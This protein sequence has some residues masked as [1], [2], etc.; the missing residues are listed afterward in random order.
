MYNE[1]KSLWLDKA[2]VRLIVHREDALH[3]IVGGN[4][5]RKLYYN[6]IHFKQN[7]YQ[8]I[9]TFGGAFSNHIAAVAYT[10]FL[11]GIKTIGIIRGNELSNNQSKNIT[12]Q[13][14]SQHGMQLVYVD[15]KTYTNRYS[16]QYHNTLLKTYGN[17]FVIPEGGCNELGMQGCAQIINDIEL[18]FDYVV[19]P[20]GTGTTLA[21]IASVVNKKQAIGIQVTQFSIDLP[22]QTILKADLENQCHLFNNA[23]PGYGKSNET[24]NAFCANFTNSFNIPIEPIYTGKMFQKL[25]Q[26]IEQGWFKRGDTIVA[27]H[28]GGLQYLQL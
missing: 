25:F 14:A 3:P 21:G 24:L 26:L 20:V 23:A 6:L 19:C 9:L 11:H 2:G 18:P 12:L 28:T 13:R 1:L 4:K 27:I 17:L 16:N 5:M 7:N 15:R 22:V 8:S 10:G